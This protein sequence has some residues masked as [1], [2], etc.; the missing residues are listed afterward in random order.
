MLS[1]GL[2]NILPPVNCRLF[3]YKTNMPE[4]T[5]WETRCFST[6]KWWIEVCGT[7]DLVVMGKTVSA[8]GW[9]PILRFGHVRVTAIEPFCG[10]CQKSLDLSK[11]GE[12]KVL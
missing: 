12:T 8:N 3:P 10:I 6:M 5:R 1:S 11:M 2:I 9:P 7:L 4:S